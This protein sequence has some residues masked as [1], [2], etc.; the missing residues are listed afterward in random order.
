M[1][2]EKK[3]YIRLAAFIISQMCLLFSTSAWA[4]LPNG[5]SLAG[6]ISFAGE[7][8]EYTFQANAGDT[9]YVR[10]ADTE[11]T[12]FINSVFSP[13]LT[14]ISPSDVV[15]RFARGSLVASVA[16]ALVESGTYTVLVRDDSSGEDE[17]GTYDIYFT[18]APGANENGRLPNGGEFS[19]EIELGDIDSYTF[20][21]NAGETVYI[22]VADIETTEFV[23][24]VFSPGI[25]L[26]NPDGEEIR[27]ARGA[28]VASIAE[29][30]VTSGVYT[31]VVRDDSSGFDATG[32]YDIF[33]AKAPGANENGV[34]TNG[35]KV[36]ENIE[37]GDI[38]SYTFQASAGETVYIRAADTET[39]EFVNSVFSPGI[40]LLDPI[41]QEV[42]FARGALVA[43]I[44][45]SLLVSGTYTV[46]VR[47]DSSGFDAT[48]AY[49][50]FYAKAP[51]AADDGCVPGGGF[52][53]GFI[54]LGDIDSFNF[55]ANAGAFLNVTVTDLDESGFSPGIALLGPNGNFIRF[56]RGTT[57]ASITETL[58]ETGTYTLILR[59]D[60]SGF[61]AVGNY[62]LNVSGSGIVCPSA[63]CNGLAVTVDLNLGQT[64]GPGDD[65][66]LGTP[67]ADDIRGRAG[68]DTICGMGGADFIHGN[69]GDDWIDGGNGVDNIRGGQG[70][71]ILFAGQG[72]TV[73]T[74]SRVFGGTGDDTIF[75]GSDADDL[76]G[77]RGDD[78][79]YGEQGADLIS[80]N[81]DDDTLFGG[82]GADSIRGGN[83]RDEL[84]GEAGT[85]SLNGGSGT[86]DFCDG[87]GQ[88]S[89]TSTNCEM[90]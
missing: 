46:V 17:T 14:L 26:L 57:T 30:L 51:G 87:G 27:F 11:T 72:A 23:N 76:R 21:A 64:P 74:N 5:G 77:G 75:G 63:L 90:F 73:T 41:G 36:S 59:D 45:E 33:F 53:S 62:R 34:L 43:S 44:A 66:V 3:I 8:D 37:L 19:D 78:V 32:A 38:D 4:N 86:N 29:S 40:T 67:G 28:L 56:A 39:T 2:C 22:R 70:A 82:P 49:A 54:E 58:A 16:E 55:S 24:S 20:Q 9:V 31:V 50:L 68:N 42:R 35:G 81:E 18:K 85:D 71:D 15:L 10:V 6:E 7:T 52:A 48:G 83:G 89:D 79:I 12:E 65:V 61:D 25:A 47:D 13:S 88:G 84:F 80:G 69:S 1:C 60:S